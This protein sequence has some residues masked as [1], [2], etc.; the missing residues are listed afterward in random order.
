MEKIPTHKVVAV[1]IDGV[2]IDSMQGEFRPEKYSPA[3]TA[4]FPTMKGCVR[5]MTRLYKAGY[6]LILYTSRTN[7]DWIH[8]MG[9]GSPEEIKKQIEFDMKFRGFPFSF[10]SIYKP[11]ADIYIDDRGWHFRDWSQME[12]DLEMLGYF[13]EEDTTH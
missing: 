8:N 9:N 3:D 13:D 1:D 6:T 7:T 10:V 5:V 12:K 11:I 2:I 4:R